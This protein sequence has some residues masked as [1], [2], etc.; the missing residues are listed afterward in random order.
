MKVKDAHGRLSL[1]PVSVNDRGALLSTVSI[2]THNTGS[3][4]RRL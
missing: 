4:H 1:R 2:A 3:I